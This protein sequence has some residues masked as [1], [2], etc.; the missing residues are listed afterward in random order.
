MFTLIMPVLIIQ[1][2]GKPFHIAVVLIF[3][4]L[5]KHQVYSWNSVVFFAD[6]VKSN[7]VILP[8]QTH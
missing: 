8:S 4:S 6:Y 3:T 2:S 5:A 7:M 1:G